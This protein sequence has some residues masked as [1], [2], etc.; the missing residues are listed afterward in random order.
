[1]C[2]TPT[3]LGMHGVSIITRLTDFAVSPG[4]VPEAAQTLPGGGV[5]VPRLADVHVAVTLAA[6]TG[7]A[8]YLWVTIETAGTPGDRDRH[9]SQRARHF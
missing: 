3:V 5:T 1:M 9:G 6:D 2:L 7:P 4:S 8:H